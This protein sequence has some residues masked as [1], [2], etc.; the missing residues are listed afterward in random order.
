MLTLWVGSFLVIFGHVHIVNK[1]DRGLLADVTKYQGSGA[2]VFRLEAL[3]FLLG[4]AI[5][6]IKN[7]LSPIMT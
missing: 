1:D 4:L 5:S 3:S 7:K 6:D 2:S